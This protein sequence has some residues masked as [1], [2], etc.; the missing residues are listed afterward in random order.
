MQTKLLGN[1]KIAKHMTPSGS[2]TLTIKNKQ[3]LLLPE[4]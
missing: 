2:S 3:D 1:E 4:L